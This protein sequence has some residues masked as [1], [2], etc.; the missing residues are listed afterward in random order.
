MPQRSHEPGVGELRHS[1]ARGLAGLRLELEVDARSPFLTGSPPLA[2]SR[3]IT[4]PALRRTSCGPAQRRPVSLSNRKRSNRTWWA[5]GFPRSSD[6][7]TRAKQGR[8][9]CCKPDRRARRRGHR[10]KTRE[11]ACRVSRPPVGHRPAAQ[12]RPTCS[13][14]H[15]P[16]RAHPHRVATVAPG[17]GWSRAIVCANRYVR[18]RTGRPRQVVT[19]SCLCKS[20]AP[21]F[22]RQRA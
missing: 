3:A 5:I 21:T 16:E 4:A 15:G 11:G 22:V 8:S 10:M 13:W 19:E 7:S 20:A 1:C 6:T 14:C 9:V 12:V 18:V 2:T 17:L